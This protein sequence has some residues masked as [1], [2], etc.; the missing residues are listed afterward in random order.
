[1]IYSV[2]WANGTIRFSLKRK[3]MTWIP[4]LILNFR[5]RKA[6][7]SEKN[8]QAVSG[9]LQSPLELDFIPPEALDIMY[10]IN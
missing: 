6:E 10:E 3:Q 9:S 5:K 4:S 8:P 7:K 1:M 2:S